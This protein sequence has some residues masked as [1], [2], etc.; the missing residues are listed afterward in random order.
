MGIPPSLTPVLITLGAGLA[1]AA[2]GLAFRAF[3]LA[4][5][6]RVAE[7]TTGQ[8]DDVLTQR[9]RGPLPLWSALLGLHFGASAAGFRPETGE[10]IRHL[11]L[12]ILILSVSW[13]A[14]SIASSLVRVPKSAGRALPS[15][16]ILS[17][18]AHSFVVLL[19]TLVALQ[20][21]GISVAPILTALGVGG[22][23]VGLAL[24]DT[25]ANL[26]AGF[27]IL[28]SRQVRPGDFVQLATGE[29][30]FVEDITWRNTTVRQLSN[31][32]VIVPNAQ[33]ARAVTLNYSLPDA[34]QAVRV[35]VGVSYAADLDHVERATVAVATEVQRDVPGAVTEFAPFIRYHTFGESSIDF[36]LIMRARQFTDSYL[37]RHEF[38]KRLRARFAN[39]GIEIPY[40]QR[41]VH[42][43]LSPRD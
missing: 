35:P 43:P 37:M 9:V 29:Q 42:L 8:V 22:L 2:V 12:A 30:G 28:A 10:S 23:A 4:R 26:F 19:G 11:L 40:P 3:I 16:R 7:R 20:T 34:E 1:G 38:V 27:H 21:M 24:Q 39:E 17:T 31:N 5:L 13:A 6:A 15:A 18:A 25:L 36:T 33:L 14:G 32:I 41:T